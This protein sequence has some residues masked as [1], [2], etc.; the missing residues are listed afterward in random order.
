MSIYHQPNVKPAFNARRSASTS[1]KRKAFTLIELLVVIAIIAI[2]ASILFPVFA[3]ARDKA[4]QTSCLSN[5]KQI[6]LALIQYN[7]DYDGQFVLATRNVTP[8]TNTSR[9]G[10]VQNVYDASWIY[11]IQP[12]VKSFQVFTCPN[13]AYDSLDGEPSANPL[14]SGLLSD[15]K[16]SPAAKPAYGSLGGPVVSYGMLPRKEYV[17]DTLSIGHFRVWNSAGYGVPP[18]G[19]YETSSPKGVRYEGV[20][21]F[22]DTAG[23][24]A[25][26]TETQGNPSFSVDSLNDNEITRPSEYIVVY[27]TNMWDGGGCGAYISQ[28]RGRHIRQ[29]RNTGGVDFTLGIANVCFADG[30]VKGMRSDTVYTIVDDATYGPYYKYLFPYD[31]SRVAP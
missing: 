26:L 4:R 16:S 22:S 29:K 13:G 3:S 24:N 17:D 8:A 27:E 21:G 20:G 25:C 23:Q 18:T 6:A 7:Q 12:Y 9:P 31:A 30:H 2:L 14:D 11:N 28:A 5:E 1:R 15:A 10:Q 19:T